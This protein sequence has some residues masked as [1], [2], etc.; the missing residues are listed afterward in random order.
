MG[1]TALHDRG[2]RS[3]ALHLR[4]GRRPTMAAF[5]DLA[6]TVSVDDFCTSP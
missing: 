5:T 2:R 6:G 3:S 4:L 1:W